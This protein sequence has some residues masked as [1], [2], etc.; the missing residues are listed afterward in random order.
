VE[1]KA[2][3]CNADLSKSSIMAD[4]ILSPLEKMADVLFIIVLTTILVNKIVFWCASL[5]KKQRGIC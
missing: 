2:G 4:N 5:T 1:A 3:E